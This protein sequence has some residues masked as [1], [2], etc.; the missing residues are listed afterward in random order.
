MRRMIPISNSKWDS[1]SIEEL[2]EWLK[3]CKLKKHGLMKR[4][5][6]LENVKHVID[7]LDDKYLFT[8]HQN[9]TDEGFKKWK[10][11]KSFFNVSNKILTELKKKVVKEKASKQVKVKKG[12]STETVSND[13]VFL[14]KYPYLFI[15][16]NIE[17]LDDVSGVYTIIQPKI[18]KMY[19]GKAK[20]IRTRL[21]SHLTQLEGEKPHFNEELQFDYDLW[22]EKEGFYFQILEINDGNNLEERELWWI[23]MFD[24]RRLY[25]VM[26]K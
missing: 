25:N 19:I 11:A 4:D 22:R 23:S 16:E 14:G 18:S 2:T 9:Y 24:R 13:M 3:E 5:I 6:T 10:E 15:L 26:G 20:N 12:D 1:F 8:H 17:S 7:S 21:K